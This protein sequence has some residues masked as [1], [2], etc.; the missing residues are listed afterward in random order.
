M[1]SQ[2]R[3]R[4]NNNVKALFRSKKQLIPDTF[5]FTFELPQP[6][7]F[8][9]GQYIFLTLQNLVSADP[10]GP[11]R[12]FSIASS[13]DDKEKISIITTV[14]RSGF[15]Q[16]LDTLTNGTEVDISQAYGNLVLP[17]SMTAPLVFIAGGMGIVPLFS[18]IREASEKRD[19]QS[20]ILIHSA[21][22]KEKMLFF[23]ELN[24]M[25]QMSSTFSFYPFE[26]GV[27]A[28]NRI[29]SANIQEFVENR[30]DSIFYIVGPEGMGVAIEEMLLN[31]GVRDEHILQEDF[32]GY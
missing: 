23:D 4:K 10:R 6:V 27:T 20:M 13:P 19:N 25:S 26:T 32:T 31:L 18:M 3:K 7:T 2:E 21:R 16:T 15:K 8:L 5:E 28:E 24:K 22:E 9:A 17:K 29:S 12:H 14:R 11:R 30:D 1:R